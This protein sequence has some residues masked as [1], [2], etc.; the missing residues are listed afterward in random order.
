MLVFFVM[1]EILINTLLKAIEVKNIIGK[2]E[3]FCLF[4]AAS[5]VFRERRFD[6]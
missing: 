2:V 1:S 6:A 5:Q 4:A 3:C